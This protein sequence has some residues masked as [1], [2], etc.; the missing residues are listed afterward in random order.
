MN[1]PHFHPDHLIRQV[2]AAMPPEEPSEGFT[3]RVMQRIPVAQPGVNLASE[4]PFNL[5]FRA[6]LA[7]LVTVG[8]FALW[9]FTRDL[10]IT[11][12]FLRVFSLLFNDFSLSSLQYLMQSL[13]GQLMNLKLWSMLAGT[14]FLIG[15]ALMVIYRMGGDRKNIGHVGSLVVFL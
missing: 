9:I 13:L 6:L 7:L 5:G 8:F 12:Q 2:F 15:G 10:S 11:D 14:V 4:A 1:T 3:E